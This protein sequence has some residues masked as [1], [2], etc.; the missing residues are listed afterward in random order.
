MNLV[1]N[2]AV[3]LINC[4]TIF[5]CLTFSEV[6]FTQVQNTRPKTIQKSKKQKQALYTNNLS[7]SSFEYRNFELRISP[8]F[9]IARWLTLDLSYRLT[10]NLAVGPI[11]TYYGS[12]GEY[13]NMF[14]PSQKGYAA[15]LNTTYYF[16]SVRRYSMYA[17]AQ[18]LYENYRSYGH[19]QYGYTDYDGYRF[20]LAFGYRWKFWSRVTLATGGGVQFNV[21]NSTEYKKDIVTDALRVRETESYNRIMPFVDLKIGVEL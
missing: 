4:L 13:G 6:A 3:R 21:K 19:A 17:M 18:A 20:D 10:E 16:A 7:E 15:G 9:L 1:R 14:L 11:G 12:E 2:R 5:A 8:I